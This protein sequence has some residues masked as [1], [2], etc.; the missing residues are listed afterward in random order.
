[1]LANRRIHL[2][3]GLIKQS[4][5]S[6]KKDK[7]F[8][9][10]CFRSFLDCMVSLIQVYV[11]LL[12]NPTWR[13]RKYILQACPWNGHVRVKHFLWPLLAGLLKRTAPDLSFLVW[14]TPWTANIW[15][16]PL[17][18]RNEDKLVFKLQDFILSLLQYAKPEMKITDSEWGEE[19]VFI[20]S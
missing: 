9:L 16:R 1:M 6:S 14:V 7:K 11:V 13:Y 3:A 18:S 19:D 5:W 2:V 15:F 8:F 20:L 12:D 4:G 10:K 17:I